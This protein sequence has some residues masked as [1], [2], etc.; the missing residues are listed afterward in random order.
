MKSIRALLLVFSVLFFMVEIFLVVMILLGPQN[1]YLFYSY[2][3]IQAVPFNQPIVNN[4]V[5]VG[6]GKMVPFNV[7]DLE[8]GDYVVA[9]NNINLDYMWVH[10]V[11]SIDTNNETITLSVNDLLGTYE[12]RYDEISGNYIGDSNLLEQLLFISTD[13][14]IFFLN[15]GAAISLTIFLSLWTIHGY[16]KFRDSGHDDQNNSATKNYKLEDFVKL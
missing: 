2:N 15:V 8:P 12:M 1:E 14:W 7:D 5:Q 6:I 9:H 11:I 16:R 13:P 4:T 3:H 10:R